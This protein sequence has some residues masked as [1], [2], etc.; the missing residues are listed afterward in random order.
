KEFGGS[1]SDAMTVG[2]LTT[3]G[4]YI[5]A[6]MSFSGAD[7]NK[8]TASYGGQDG[9][10]MKLSSSGAVQWEKVFG[11]SGSEYVG[12]IQQTSDGGFILALSSNSPKSG[13]KGVDGF[14]DY[15]FWI[16]K[17]DANGTF[18]WEKA[19]GGSNRET[20]PKIKPTSDGG[21]ILAG[22]TASGISGNKTT[23]NNSDDFW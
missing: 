1:G 23:S 13:N 10:V 15:D 12:D 20:G 6:G 3:D 9:W 21:Y 11:G 16:V 2:R 5:V 19:Y 7:G 17:I 8:T 4:G 14:G 22:L 18:Q